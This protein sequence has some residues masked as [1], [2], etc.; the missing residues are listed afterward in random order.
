MVRDASVVLKKS[1]FDGMVCRVLRPAV[2]CP[3]A[4]VATT[5]CLVPQSMADPDIWWH[6]RNAQTLMTTHR[7]IG[8]DTYSF[9][10]KGTP[11]INHEWLSELPFYFGWS[12]GREWGLYLVTI[13]IVELLILGIFLLAYK[14][15]DSY[16]GSLT[17]S[18]L[19]AI[20]STV[21]Y[22]PRTILFGW[23]YL[24]VELLLLHAITNRPQLAWTL[25]LLFACWVNTHGSWM[26]GMIVML[27]TI[28]LEA[29]NFRRGDLF[30]EGLSQDRLATLLVAPILSIGALFLNPYGWRMV[31]YPFDLAFHQKLNVANVQEWK[32]LDLHS[33]RGMILLSVLALFPLSQLCRSRSWK[34]YEVVYLYL[35][36][37]AAFTYVRFLVLFSILSVPVLA[38]S[39]AW[40]DRNESKDENQ[41]PLTKAALAF[42]LIC[43]MIG[44]YRSAER[45]IQQEDA[46]YPSEAMPLLA[47]LHPHGRVFNEYLWGGYMI[48]HLPEIPVFIDSRVDIFEYNGTLKDY[49]DIVRVENSLALL[50]KHKIQY[51][52]F[53]RDTPL[54]YLL[55]HAGGW[56]MDFARGNIVLIERCANIPKGI[57]T[58]PNQAER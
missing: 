2:L 26:I 11:W 14:K 30:S 8:T 33:P 17:V 20:L 39:F 13:A 9:T 57:N 18:I 55:E 58:V 40:S 34:L 12:I 31:A 50:D 22:G 23:L 27:A 48:W 15:S 4:L 43:L 16:S 25:P 54:V 36:I 49:L 41:I 51:V 3:L 1:F 52:F 47:E 35:G 21:T 32:N 6:L 46:A 7:F 53:E 44:R 24:V 56:R 45:S 10:A 5:F 37:Y 19:A 42:F 38:A 28:A 29:I